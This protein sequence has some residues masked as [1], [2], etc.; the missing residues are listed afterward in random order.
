MWWK[1]FNSTFKNNFF[2]KLGLIHPLVY[3]VL[4]SFVFLLLTLR[5]KP[6]TKRQ[7]G[8]ILVSSLAFIGYKIMGLLIVSNFLSGSLL[9]LNT[10]F[11][12]ESRIFS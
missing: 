9:G 1:A 7:K 6:W 10:A 11:D 8:W 4:K 5:K 3:K 12:Q 2:I